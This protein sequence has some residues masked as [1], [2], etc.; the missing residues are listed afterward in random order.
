MVFKQASISCDC[1]VSGIARSTDLRASAFASLGLVAA[2]ALGLASC[3]PSQMAQIDPKYGVSP[4]PRVVADGNDIPKG[5]GYAKVGKPYVIAGETYVPRV[6][7]TY[8]STGVA[9]WYGTDFHGRKTANGE[10]FDSDS[11]TAAH[12]TLPLP[13]YIRVTNITNGRSI[14]ARVND[15]GPFHSS[16]LIDVSEPVAEALQ[17]KI[18]GTAKVKVDY[19]GQAPIDGSDDKTLLASL[20]TDGKP[21]TLIGDARAPVQVAEAEPVQ[22][23][24][25]APVV[26]PQLVAMNDA[27]PVA[28]GEE[29]PFPVPRPATTSTV[30]SL[31]PAKPVLSSATPAAPGVQTAGIPPLPVPR[32][33][34]L[35]YVEPTGSFTAST[36]AF[37]GL[38]SSPTFSLR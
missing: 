31:I 1:H 38:K 27:S 11:I 6:P 9:S 2:L 33:G 30:V 22:M 35:F 8:S 32:P 4:S 28:E 36:P 12:R 14:I 29:V 37:T 10:V 23:E 16:R 26:L 15:R 21:A 20:R 3:S 24:E 19:L 5:G 34:S 13:S 17:F 18:A 25:P 7:K